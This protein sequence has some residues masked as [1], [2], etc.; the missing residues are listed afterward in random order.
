M[1]FLKSC[2]SHLLVSVIDQF[3]SSIFWT[4]E[5]HLGRVVLGKLYAAPAL[6]KESDA[7]FLSDF[8][9]EPHC[10]FLW[11]CLTVFLCIHFQNLAPPRVTRTK[12][13]QNLYSTETQISIGEINSMQP[14]YASLILDGVN[15]L[16]NTSIYFF[17]YFEIK[18]IGGIQ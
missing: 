3:A 2:V 10:H 13:M 5:T 11:N 8:F 4:A 16:G 14:L 18:K 17:E 1:N 7:F 12:L 9:T 6:G 15:S